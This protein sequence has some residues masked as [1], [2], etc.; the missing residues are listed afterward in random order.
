[1]GMN[2]I[3]ESSEKSDGIDVRIF[4]IL[5][6]WIREHQNT[7]ET[8]RYSELANLVDADSV[9]YSNIGTRLGR[10]SNYSRENK[11]PPISA[12]VI[13]SSNEPGEGFFEALGYDGL[14]QEKKT[15]IWI[16][17]LN[18]IYL[19]PIKNWEKLA[20]KYRAFVGINQKVKQ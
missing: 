20:E 4:D 8:I 11:F 14:S 15:E 7:R 13:N 1:M 2:I 17:L 16:S 5:V 3:K 10:V 9:A 12:I 6:K 18:E 19:T